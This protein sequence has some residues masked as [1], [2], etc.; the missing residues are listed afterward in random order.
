MIKIVKQYRTKQSESEDVDDI[1]VMELS[2]RLRNQEKNQNDSN[3]LCETSPSNE[4]SFNS[5]SVLS[6]REGE[7]FDNQ[8][9]PEKPEEMLIDEV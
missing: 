1:P 7:P 4:D 5:D 9:S 6:N 8:M 2:K 3:K